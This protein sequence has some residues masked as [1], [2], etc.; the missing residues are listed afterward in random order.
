MSVTP[1]LFKFGVGLPD[2]FCKNTGH[3]V[4]SD[5]SRLCRKRVCNSTGLS[6]ALLTMHLFFV[7]FSFPFHEAPTTFGLKI[8]KQYI[9]V[10]FVSIVSAK[11]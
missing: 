1:T 7:L 3:S 11:H 9:N 6:N 5:R 10:C 2:V 8:F 4:N